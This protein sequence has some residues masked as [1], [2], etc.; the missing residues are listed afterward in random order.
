VYLYSERQVSKRNK[1]KAERLDKLMDNIG[2]VRAQVKKDLKSSDLET[3]LV[4]LAVGLMDHTAERVGNE[5]SAEE[6]H[7]GVTGWTK[8]HLSFGKGKAKLKYVGKSGVSHDKQVT[9]AA[10]VKALKDASEACEGGIFVH[11]D[12]KVTAQKVNEYLKKFDITAKDLRG[13]HANQVMR[14]ELKKIRKGDLPK[15]AK[16]R[17]KQLKEEFKKALE[18]TAENVGHTSSTLR[19]QYL[20]PGLEDEYMM[21]RIMERM[22]KE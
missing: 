20:T 5:D 8:D 10:L 22:T 3:R 14:D 17:K 1:D 9:D 16:E 18:I 11:K 2:K 19:N 12:T 21:G 7:F 15:D 13:L 4:A 6:G